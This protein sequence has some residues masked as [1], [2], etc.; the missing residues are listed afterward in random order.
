MANIPSTIK[1][2]HVTTAANIPSIL[3]RGVSPD[4][5]RGKLKVCWFVDSMRLSWAIAH[6]SQR[7]GFSVADLYVCDVWAASEYFKRT[8]MP[9]VFT[10]SGR[11][12][13]WDVRKAILSLRED[14]LDQ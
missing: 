1:R 7:S 4:F 14:D 11:L 10:A 2:Y 5:S 9:G 13:V 3:Q 6:V 12:F 8:R